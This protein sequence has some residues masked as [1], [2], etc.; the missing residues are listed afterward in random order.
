MPSCNL[1]Q[2]RRRNNTHEVSGQHVKLA[3]EKPDNH[4]VA[5]AGAGWQ[6]HKSMETDAL[7]FTLPPDLI[8]QTPPVERR[9]ARL[10]H[11]RR[12]GRTVAHRRFADLPAILRPG[13]L[14][15]MNDARVTPARFELL[16]PTGGRVEA[17]FLS[18]APDGAWHVLLRDLGP[19]RVD[20]PLRLE[21]EPSAILTLTEKREA[22][23]YVGRL[24][25]DE[26]ADAVLTRIGR[27]PLPPYIKRDKHADARDDADRER[28]QTVYASAPGSV[29]APTA[30]L[31]FDAPLLAELD[32]M[33]ICRT[34][35]TLHVGIGTFKPV[36]ASRLEDHAMHTERFVLPATAVAAINLAKEE[37]RRVIA[38]G[39]T[40]CRVLESQ[41]PGPLEAGKGDTQ[42]FIRPP[43]VFQ[44][45]DALVT[46]FHL[47]RSTL[48]AL[49]AA[50]M[51]LD[52][53]R[54]IYAEAIAGHYRFF[55]YGDGS[56]LE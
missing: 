40:A 34:A 37:G 27:M 41:P 13:D 10:L 43:Y 11:Y 47:P 14:L 17:L 50:F 12:E 55:S 24:S 53:Q 44:H 56:L 38:V 39:T 46:N 26:P 45:V 5:G 25:I 36:T 49:V 52:E 15:V 1:K 16:K 8:A 42:I 54:R 32:Q 33:K 2:V 51:G 20:L 29:A 23:Q 6:D 30:G 22:G 31:H 9:A 7:D 21:R 3:A 18:E 19:Y 4:G 48:I 35:V 28:Y